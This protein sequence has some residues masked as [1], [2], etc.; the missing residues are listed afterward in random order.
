VSCLYASS[1]LTEDD[2]PVLQRELDVVIESMQ[3]CITEVALRGKDS[4][5]AA[6]S[7]AKHQK[8]LKACQCMQELLVIVAKMFAATTFEEQYPM[9]GHNVFHI[10]NDVL[11]LGKDTQLTIVKEMLDGPRR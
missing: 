10:L 11:T 6:M 3:V 8:T 2:L 1:P 5:A 9:A 7:A 4:N